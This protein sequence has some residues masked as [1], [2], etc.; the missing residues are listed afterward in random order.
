[1]VL[2]FSYISVAFVSHVILLIGYKILF[3]LG[4]F[5]LPFFLFVFKIFIICVNALNTK[6]VSIFD[7][8]QIGFF[9]FLLTIFCV[10]LDELLFYPGPAI[11]KIP[12]FNP[13]A[14][15]KSSVPS[16]DI[17]IRTPD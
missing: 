2:F 12:N 13:G 5:V 15:V 8:I 10:C 1:M 7:V 14:V 4:I 6:H 9:C 11:K 3:A 16:A 17:K